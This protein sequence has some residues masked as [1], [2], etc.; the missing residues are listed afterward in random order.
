[1]KKR[2]RKMKLNQYQFI[3][4]YIIYFLFCSLNWLRVWILSLL[5]K[6][7]VSFIWSETIIK[8]SNICFFSFSSSVNNVV[9]FKK[10]FKFSKNHI[11]T[12]A[13]GKIG[14]RFE[15]HLFWWFLSYASGRIFYWIFLG[16]YQRFS[17][18]RDKSLL[19]LSLSLECGVF[20]TLL[21]FS[22]FSFSFIVWW[23]L[24]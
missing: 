1:M 12:L 11:S 22:I 8:K 7:F 24:A 10:G 2:V 3:M 14:I 18:L 4:S 9:V 13:F 16:S 21:F 5:L 17:Y 19:D 23:F 20:L 15:F 6:N